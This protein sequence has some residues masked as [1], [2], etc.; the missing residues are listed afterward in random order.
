MLTYFTSASNDYQIRVSNTSTDITMSL[1][2]MST[3]ENSNAS[4]S[5]VEIVNQYESLLA[6][7]ASISGAVSGDEYRVTIVVSG[8]DEPIY[9]G[10]LQVFVSQSEDKPSYTNQVP[11]AENGEDNF[12]SRTSSNSYIILN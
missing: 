9:N 7:T 2:N 10:S 11:L 8:S 3:L 5:G 1:Q 12:K 6:F 4:L